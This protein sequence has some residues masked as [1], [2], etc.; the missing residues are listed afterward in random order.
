MILFRTQS[1]KI[2]LGMIGINSGISAEH[3]R[4][5]LQI[6][7]LQITALC[8]IK[9]E[10]MKEASKNL[11]LKP[12]LYTDYRKMLNSEKLDAVVIATPN[13]LH[14]EMATASLEAGFHVFCEKPMAR[15]AEECEEMLKAQKKAGRF[16]QIGMHRR[17]NPLYE[18]VK[19]IIDSGEIGNLKMLWG[20][21]FRG[22]WKKL[23]DDF[24]ENSKIN[25]RYSQ[26]LSGGTSVE[27]ICHDMDVFNWLIGEP[28]K[29][30]FASGTVGFY[31]KD[32]RDTVDNLN[33]IAEYSNNV[34]TNFILS[35]FTPFMNL[36]GRHYG[37]IGTE[38]NLEI[39]EHQF[40]I[41]KYKRAEKTHQ[42]IYV[43]SLGWP[44]SKGHPASLA[45]WKAFTKSLINNE[46]PFCDGEKGKEAVRI[47]AACEKSMQTGKI[48][49]I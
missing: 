8:D 6:P 4:N 26:K 39:F 48:V 30:I 34:K 24:N 16:L 42:D 49:E 21:E 38:G 9:Q 45:Q 7:E 43:D 12:R 44:E 22:D 41:R 40:L 13:Y 11:P 25:W 19:K 14:K 29:R 33:L 35:L 32:G 20:H 10:N 5:I 46:P 17:Y 28:A 47:C 36:Q 15:T 37:I 2:K 3:M 23:S 1:K 31:N 18:Q 27:K